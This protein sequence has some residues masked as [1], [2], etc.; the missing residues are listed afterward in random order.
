MAELPA[1][2]ELV[3]S[4]FSVFHY[5]LCDFFLLSGSA[6]VETAVGHACE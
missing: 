4:L 6:R 2:V 1:T 5:V 3:G